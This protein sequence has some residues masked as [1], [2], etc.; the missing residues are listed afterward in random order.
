[1]KHRV[2]IITFLS[3]LIAGGAIML[4]LINLGIVPTI[5]RER[6]QP[7]TLRDTASAAPGAEPAHVRGEASA[8]VLIEEFGDFQC[9]PC[10]GLYPELKRIESEYGPQRLRVVFRN[11]PLEIH[12][13]A[14][15]AAR[16]AEAAAMQGK[17]WE[18]HDKLY[19][20]Q[21][22]WSEACDVNE[23]FA[24]YARELGLD[25]ERFKKDMNS[26]QVKE[27]VRLDLTRAQ[28]I[29][30]PG[31]PTLFINGHQVPSASMTPEGLRA[32]INEAA[33]KKS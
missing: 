33:G 20:A 14:E 1:M 6:V 3:G 21:N 23:K 31:T 10:A 30:V 24:A 16:A 22:D 25:V 9:P 28:S 4:S 26:E 18:M 32:K 8:P 17:F 13:H 29:D 19:E 27:R 15:E 7:E 12:K 5:K 11:L 2:D